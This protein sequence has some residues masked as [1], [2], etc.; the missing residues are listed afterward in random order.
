MAVNDD[1]S[2]QN[3]PANGKDEEFNRFEHAMKELLTVPK[4]EMDAAVDKAKQERAKRPRR[5]AT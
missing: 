5:R 4:R 2:P 3:E 1:E